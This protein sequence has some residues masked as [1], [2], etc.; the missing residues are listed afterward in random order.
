MGAATI[1]HTAPTN[2]QRRNMNDQETNEEPL[3]NQDNDAYSPLQDMDGD[4][5]EAYIEGERSL[6]D[7][8]WTTL[9]GG[10]TKPPKGDD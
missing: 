9:P 1:N 10:A 2:I 4:E 8:D 3:I 5:I 7:K 6:P